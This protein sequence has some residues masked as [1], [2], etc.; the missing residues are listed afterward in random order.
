M[1]EKDQKVA[2]SSTVVKEMLIDIAGGAID[3]I[4]DLGKDN[5]DGVDVMVRGST[6][7]FSAPAVK[8]MLLDI[9]YYIHA[10]VKNIEK[11][12]ETYVIDETND[13]IGE[14]ASALNQ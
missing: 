11:A 14:I 12:E 6:L 9:T 7:I 2:Y 8:R 5:M 1:V 13:I 4:I 3:K 10:K